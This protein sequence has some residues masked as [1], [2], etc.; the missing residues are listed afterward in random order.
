MK[1]KLLFLLLML[2]SLA[3]KAEVKPISGTFINFF[4]QDERNN[5]MNQRNVDQSDPQRWA[6]KIGELHEM[7]VDLLIIVTVANE[8]RAMYPCSF[9]EH[10]YP[11]GRKSPVDAI[12]DTA[13]SLGMK[14]FIGCGWAR[15]QL[16]DLTDPYVIETNR[17]FMDELAELYSRRPSFE[18][19]YIPVEGCFIPYLSD[20]AV[21]GVNK[22]SAHARELTP[23]IKVLISPYGLFGADIENPL[24]EKS[25]CDLDVDI[26]A[27]QDEVGCVREQ[28]P[29]KNMKE[30]FR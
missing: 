16:D 24:F 19:W 20:Y 6:C 13:D 18:G 1:R 8:G 11:E 23:G 12:M 5:Y 4:W 17:H 28:F 3:V 7:G 10:G 22:I 21:Q 29:M 14:V 26:I 9:M 15:D 30:H 27:Y 25:I 2:S